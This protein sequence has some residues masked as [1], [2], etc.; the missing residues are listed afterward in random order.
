[1]SMTP[2]ERYVTAFRHEEPDRVPVDLQVGGNTIG[3]PG[4]DQ[5]VHL[6]GKG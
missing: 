6:E 1:M 2:R 5:F 3:L 4:V